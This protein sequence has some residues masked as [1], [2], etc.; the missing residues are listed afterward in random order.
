MGSAASTKGVLEELFDSI[1]LLWKR[2]HLFTFDKPQVE[3]IESRWT[4]DLQPVGAAE[5]L[6]G[7]L[8]ELVSS[9][10]SRHRVSGGSGIR[11]DILEEDFFL[12][13]GL[14]DLVVSLAAANAAPPQDGFERLPRTT[15][16]ISSP[17]RRRSRPTLRRSRPRTLTTT[18]SS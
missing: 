8:V 13:G 3:G 14:D 18:R 11:F 15:C 12:T 2:V 9:V 16:F 5:V 7:E 1:G 6:S 10:D 4:R 17:A